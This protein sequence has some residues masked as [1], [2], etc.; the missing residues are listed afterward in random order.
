MV[1][2]SRGL[3]AETFASARQFLE[4]VKPDGAGCVLTDVRMP[5]I[6]GIELLVKMKEAG[7]T[8]PVIVMTAYANVPLA[9]QAMKEGAIDLLEKPFKDDAL[10]A[11]VRAALIYGEDKRARDNEIRAIRKKLETLTARENDVLAGLLK[12]R[13]NKIIAYDLGIGVRTVET[14]RATIMEKMGAGSLSELLRMSL[15]SGVD[16][17]DHSK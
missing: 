10:L 2:E 1:L 8:L 7:L 16:A 5:D 11:A 17:S 3:H 14:H 15:I 13:P 9:V 12:G 4:S 6:G